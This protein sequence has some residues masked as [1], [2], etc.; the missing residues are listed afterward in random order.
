[1]SLIPALL[2]PRWW[3]LRKRFSDEYGGAYS[4]VNNAGYVVAIVSRGEQL[5]YE[6][7]LG[8]VK[9]P[10]SL[11]DKCIDA[12]ALKLEVSAARGKLILIRIELYFKN[13]QGYSVQVVQS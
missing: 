12:R 1:M 13:Y 5:L 8:A 4:E 7:V 10:I 9:V 11:H 3:A 2:D 6:D